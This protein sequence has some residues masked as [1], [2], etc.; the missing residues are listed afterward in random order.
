MHVT[1]C[2]WE[3]DDNATYDL[4][5]LFGTNSENDDINN[6][7]T[8]GAIHAPSN[9]DMESFKLGDDG[10]EN[11]LAISDVIL[12]NYF[13]SK[14]EDDM[15]TNIFASKDDGLLY[16]DDIMTPIYDD[17]NDTYDIR[18]NYPY[19]TCHNYGGNYSLLNTISLI[20]N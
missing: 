12:D 3:N 15:F 14:N 13:A 10:L 18:K 4:E 19:E 17:C 16:Y 7:Y 20:P 6:C 5:N 11:P 8:I 9:D 2:D 1:Y